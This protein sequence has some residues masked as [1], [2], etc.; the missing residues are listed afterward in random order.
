METSMKEDSVWNYHVWNEV[1]MTRPDLNTSGEDY[2][3]WQASRCLVIRIN[4]VNKN[5]K[6]K[7]YFSRLNTAR[8]VRK[9]GEHIRDYLAVNILF[10]CLLC[11]VINS[12]SA[13]QHP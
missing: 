6:I 1:W 5:I 4:I 3:G 7:L 8:N 12:S 10:I 2:D 13:A 11:N 9:Y